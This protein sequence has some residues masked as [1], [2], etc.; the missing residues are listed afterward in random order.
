MPLHEFY[1][2][3]AFECLVPKL[4]RYRYNKNFGT[5]F[6]EIQSRH[7]ELLQVVY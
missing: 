7:C 3:E 1:M 2:L 6:A 5:T 4:P